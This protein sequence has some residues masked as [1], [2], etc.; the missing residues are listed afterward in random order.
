MPAKRDKTRGLHRRADAA[1][2]L[3]DRLAFERLL[4][5][6]AARFSNAAPGE[7]AGAIDA[8]MRQL[9]QFFDYDRCSYGEFGDDGKLSVVASAGAAGVTPHELGPFGEKRR[10]FLDELLAGRPVVLPALPKGLPAH[11]TAGSSMCGARGCA[12]ISRSRSASA[13]APPGCCHSLAS[14]RRANGRTISSCA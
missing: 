14:A 1:L 2:A 4:A 6:L 11:A 9:V 7:V 3:I 5:D 10:W 13:A 12:P 8:A